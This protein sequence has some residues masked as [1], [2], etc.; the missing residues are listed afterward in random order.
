V[1]LVSPQRY[2]R[3]IGAV[4]ARHDASR[5]SRDTALARSGAAAAPGGGFAGR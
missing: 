4:T 2:R 5:A 1:I 3:V